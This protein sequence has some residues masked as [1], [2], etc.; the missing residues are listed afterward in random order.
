MK[1]FLSLLLLGSLVIF[2]GTALAGKKCDKSCS[3][4]SS[5]VGAK[6]KVVTLEGEIVEA[7]C[8]LANGET[9]KE[10]ADCIKK[11]AAE[12][13]PLVLVAKDESVYL[14]VKNADTAK[15]YEQTI[16]LAAEKVEIKGIVHSK[17]GMK[18]I[19]VTEIKQLEL[20][21]K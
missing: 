15:A 6:G 7:G 13:M 12:G 1:R 8:F 19:A 11:C 3:E 9:A 10:N 21:A 16:K 2:M 17:D 20:A 5:C 14:I 4:F 18:A